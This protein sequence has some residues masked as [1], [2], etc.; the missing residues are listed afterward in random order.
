MKAE[1]LAKLE[2]VFRVVLDLPEGSDVSSIRRLTTRRWDSLAHVSMVAA[3]E[4][5]LGVQL[6][7]SSSERLTSFQAAKLLIEERLDSHQ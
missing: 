5:E 2:E 7:T 1:D 4:S 3:I 6:D